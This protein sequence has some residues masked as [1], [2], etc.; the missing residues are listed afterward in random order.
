MRH[1]RA[2]PPPVPASPPAGPRG[3]STTEIMLSVAPYLWPRGNLGARVRVVTAVAF[4]ILA[5][6]AAVYVP[7]L[8][9]RSV[10]ALTAPGNSGRR[11][12]SRWRCRRSA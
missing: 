5:K 7:I 6:F 1:M 9:G 2:A 11:A 4:M 10:D 12:P 3:L 8:Y